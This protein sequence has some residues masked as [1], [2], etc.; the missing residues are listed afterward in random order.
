MEGFGVYFAEEEK[1]KFYAS[2]AKEPVPGTDYFQ[3][4]VLKCEV[5]VCHGARGW[6]NRWASCGGG[7]GGGC[8]SLLPH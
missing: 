2:L 8:G 6:M 7:G 5:C 3:G 4:A 1:A